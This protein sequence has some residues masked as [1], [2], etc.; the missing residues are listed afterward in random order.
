MANL[1]TT[2]FNE[3]MQL[4]TPL[5]VDEAT[6][7]ANLRLALPDSLYQQIHFNSPAHPFTVQ[8]IQALLQ[9]GEVKP[10]KQAIIALLDVIHDQVGINKQREIEQLR[11]RLLAHFQSAEWVAC[12][13]C[14]VSNRVTAKFCRSCGKELLAAPVPQSAQTGQLRR[15][16]P[17]SSLILTSIIIPLVIAGAIW[18]SWPLLQRIS[19]T[20]PI[21]TAPIATSSVSTAIAASGSPPSPNTT[22]AITPVGN[23]YQTQLNAREA[24]LKA[25]DICVQTG[26]V[27]AIKAEGE[28]EVGTYA[29]DG[30][31]VGPEGTER[32]LLGLPIG[33]NYDLVPAFPHA[34]LMFRI[35]GETAWRSYADPTARTFTVPATGC[36]EFQ[37]NDNDPGNNSDTGFLNIT[38]SVTPA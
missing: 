7:R 31:K 14:G 4:L 10:G 9:Y 18:G 8:M 15:V 3:L 19:V 25:T 30:G 21:T 20:P 27:V 5:M 11:Q 1:D 36:L 35:V 24:Y 2:T 13:R 23:V 17:V 16:W 22:M 32:G 12:P 29:G 34:V 38:V 37:L 28:I 33:D 6:R 26:D